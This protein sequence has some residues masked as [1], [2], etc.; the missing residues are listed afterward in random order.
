[1]AKSARA[2]SSSKGSSR[3][4]S[5]TMDKIAKAAMS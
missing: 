5:D 2:K 1:M 4:S 3:S